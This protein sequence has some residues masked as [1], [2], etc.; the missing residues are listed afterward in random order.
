MNSKPL[1]FL[2]LQFEENSRQKFRLVLSH[3]I[4]ASHI[5]SYY[6]HAY[7]SMCVRESI[8]S[9]VSISHSWSWFQFLFYSGHSLH[10]LKLT[11]SSLLSKHSWLSSSSFPCNHNAPLNQGKVCFLEAAWFC[12]CAEL[13]SSCIYSSEFKLYLLVPPPSRQTL[14]ILGNPKGGR[15][16]T[17]SLCD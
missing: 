14:N 17:L 15:L 2:F 8:V 11:S 1:K 10:W 7:S 4:I 12:L 3:T 5:Y 13:W 16:E 9:I 6:S